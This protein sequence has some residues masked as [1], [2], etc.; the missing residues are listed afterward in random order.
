M[1]KAFVGVCMVVLLCGCATKVYVGPGTGI[2]AESQLVLSRSLSDVI[3]RLD[4]SK[5]KGKRVRVELFGMGRILGA[6]PTQTLIYSLLLEKILED[7]LLLEDDHSAEIFLA[8][9]VRVA[10]VDVVRRDL[11][12]FYHHTS[13]RGCVSL[14]TVAYDTDNYRIMDTQDVTAEYRYREHYWFY[15][16]GPYRSIRRLYPP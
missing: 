1:M 8:V 5:F 13:F 16:I 11:P 14:R 9:S 4:F 6:R 7:G 15:I 12:P 10:G 3:D 2:S